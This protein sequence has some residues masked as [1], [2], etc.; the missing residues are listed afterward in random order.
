MRMLAKPWQTVATAREIAE[1]LGDPHKPTVESAP[2]PEP[3][4]VLSRE[5]MEPFIEKVLKRA[6]REG[7][8]LNEATPK[9]I[10]ERFEEAV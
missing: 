6:Y 8:N 1:S 10:Q 7:L 3:L 4:R 5:M 2:A 9:A